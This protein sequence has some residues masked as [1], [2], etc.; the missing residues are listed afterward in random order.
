MIFFL[1]FL[2][3]GMA[4][5]ISMD[6]EKPSISQQ[7]KGIFYSAFLFPLIFGFAIKGHLV[8]IEKIKNKLTEE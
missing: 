1:W 5:G 2:L 8:N 4:Y 6:E 3:F 7:V